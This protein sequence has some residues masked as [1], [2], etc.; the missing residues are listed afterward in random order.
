MG[1]AHSQAEVFWLHRQGV[2]RWIPL[3]RHC[4]KVR[5]HRGA[6]ALGS[7]GASEKKQEKK[8]VTQLI[9]HACMVI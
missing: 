5:A 1:E 8:H 7:G 3:V 9:A 6:Q 4:L 2:Q